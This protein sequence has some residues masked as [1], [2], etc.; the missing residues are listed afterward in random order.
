MTSWL[1][2]SAIP[3][4]AKPQGCV[5]LVTLLSLR[6]RALESRQ[7]K[8]CDLVTRFVWGRRRGHW[9][10]MSNLEPSGFEDSP[11]EIWKGHLEQQRHH[12]A[13]SLSATCRLGSPT[14]RQ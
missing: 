6:T 13:V 9:V 12:L 2:A 11:S 8:V 3:V 10:L 5:L 14:F 7:R 4:A 1:H